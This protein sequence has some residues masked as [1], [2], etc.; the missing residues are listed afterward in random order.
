VPAEVLTVE[1]DN[2]LRSRM[3]GG[4]FQPRVR[5]FRS[6][7]EYREETRYTPLDFRKESLRHY[8]VSS[9]KQN[10]SA[11]FSRVKIGAVFEV[12]LIAELAILSDLVFLL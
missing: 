3:N 12:G 11:C 8:F 2:L 1:L 4:G 6:C 5:S 9:V 7:T 10:V